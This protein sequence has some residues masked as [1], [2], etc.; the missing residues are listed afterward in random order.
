MSCIEQA[1]QN[2]KKKKNRSVH[3]ELLFP[4][5]DPGTCEATSAVWILGA[6]F[7]KPSKPHWQCKFPTKPNRLNGHHDHY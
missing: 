5:F 2:V 4:G 1:R 6:Y 7:E 3:W